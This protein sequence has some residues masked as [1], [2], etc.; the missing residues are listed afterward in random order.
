M[1][2]DDAGN[3]MCC[4]EQVKRYKMTFNGKKEMK[5]SLKWKE[6]LMGGG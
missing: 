4:N 1:E 3:E 6:V 5:W 2:R